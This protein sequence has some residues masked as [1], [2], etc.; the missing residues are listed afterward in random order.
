MSGIFCFDTFSVRF[1]GHLCKLLEKGTKKKCMCT[2]FADY[3]RNDLQSI[4]LGGKIAA[5]Q[6]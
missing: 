1:V 6:S 5:Y 3:F 2:M 4:H